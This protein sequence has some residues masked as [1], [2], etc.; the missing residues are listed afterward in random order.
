M[1]RDYKLLNIVNWFEELCA[2]AEEFKSIYLIYPVA[3]GFHPETLRRIT[4][5]ANTSFD[6]AFI[7]YDTGVEQ[8]DDQYTE[9]GFVALSQGHTLEVWNSDEM[10]KDEFTLLCLNPDEGDEIDDEI[11]EGFDNFE[12]KSA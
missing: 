11:L 3:V 9:M 5:I 1:Q 8:P 4:L 2:A 7:E 12:T 10:L 6:S